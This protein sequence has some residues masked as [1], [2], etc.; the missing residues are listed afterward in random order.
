LKLINLHSHFNLP[1][2]HIG[3]VNHSLLLPFNPR[4]GQCYSVGLHPWNL[5]EIRNDNW[6]QQLEELLQH[7]Q[8]LAVGECGI[9]R[10]LETP[11]K[12]QTN[13]FLP[14]V[15][16]AGQFDKPLI[17]HA[18]RSYSDLLQLK[19]KNR[20]NIPWI[21]HGYR[22]NAETTKQ[23]ARL[24]FFFSVG[25][26]LLNGNRQLNQSLAEIPR[27]QLFFETD[28]SSVDIESIYIFAAEK[29][30]TP[31]QTLQQQVFDNYQQVFGK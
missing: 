22:G 23:L 15:H 29:L 24:G 1:N 14:Q 8:I 28:E 6:V 5:D 12:R 21:L 17:L 30:N 4:E 3:L 9:D 27:N 25:A 18:V 2:E 20:N 13:Y 11:V 10:S 7:P 31:L 19:K 16:L 26:A